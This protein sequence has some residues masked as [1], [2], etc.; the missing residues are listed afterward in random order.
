MNWIVLASI[1]ALSY[2]AYN[3]FIKLSS[4]H[5]NQIAGAVILQ[6]VALIAGL[7]GLVYLK[8]NN[9][10]VKVTHAGIRYAVYAGCFVGFAE[11]LSFYFFSSGATASRGVPVIIGGS[12][13]V[14][15][16]LG[17]IVLQEPLGVRDWVGVS[18][19]VAGVA[20]LS[21]REHMF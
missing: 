4:S 6:S 10:P 20:I 15:T 12:V 8:V 14:C 2:G 16:L 18:L 7:G 9:H 3:F 17:L 13:I 11:V 21:V 1:V 5:I 19:I